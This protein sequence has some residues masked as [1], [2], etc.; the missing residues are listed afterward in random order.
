MRSHAK[1]VA[2][3]LSDQ[4]KEEKGNE[5]AALEALVGRCGFCPATLFGR[6]PPRTAAASICRA[7][8]VDVESV[9]PHRWPP[10]HGAPVYGS[11]RERAC[12]VAARSTDKSLTNH[13]SYR[14]ESLTTCREGLE[15]TSDK[16]EDLAMGTI[17]K[18]RYASRHRLP[19]S[20][21]GR[22]LIC[23]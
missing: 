7:I 11:S 20:R 5:E 9:E 18:V 19:F 1:S 17:V 12:P 23:G 21:P 14:I 22:R 13:C 16:V 10:P 2:S 3:A 15:L 4:R 8:R 6:A